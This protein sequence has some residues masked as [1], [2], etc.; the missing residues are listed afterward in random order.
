MVYKSDNWQLKFDR[1]ALGEGIDA[2]IRFIEKEGKLVIN[3]LSA[4]AIG[5]IRQ[6][7]SDKNDIAV[8][9]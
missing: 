1:D 5:V 3:N 6:A 2:E 7:I 8:A 9:D 4:A